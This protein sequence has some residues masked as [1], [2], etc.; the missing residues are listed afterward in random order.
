MKYVTLNDTANEIEIPIKRRPKCIILKWLPWIGKSTRAKKQNLPIVNRDTLRLDNPTLKEKDIKQIQYELLRG[1]YE[2]WQDCILD[3]T[4]MFPWSSESAI[5]NCKSIWFEVEVKDLMSWVP[6]MRHKEATNN[7]KNREERV[8]QCIID[9]MY[10]SNYK[11]SQDTFWREVYIF[12]LDWTLANLEH[13]LH[14]VKWEWKKDWDSF[15]RE[16]WNDTIIEN[17]ARVFNSLN[18]PTICKIV[19]SWR[20]AQCA[21]ETEEW[22]SKFG[23]KYDFILMRDSRDKRNDYDV[24]KDLYNMCLKWNNILWVF[25]D[26]KQVIDMW[27][28]EWV[29]VFD[30]WQGKVF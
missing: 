1:Y 10:L 29:F 4:H 6:I 19:V 9:K 20:S 27:I 25:D 21:F 8:P 7:N 15:F 16:V 13:R 23:L 26:R 22:L 5:V 24:K 2:A 11:V 3:N 18:S 17:V 28:E 14:Y 30:V 12:D